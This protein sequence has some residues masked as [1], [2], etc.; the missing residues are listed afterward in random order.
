MESPPRM[1]TKKHEVD[2]K[3]RVF[4]KSWTAKYFFKEVSSK[5]LCLICSE[6]GAVFKDYKLSHHLE[7]KHTEKY[8]NLSEEERVRTTEALLAK[9]QKQQGL[10]TKLHATKKGQVKTRNALAHKNCQKKQAVP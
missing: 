1:S 7:T 3:C 9:L 4:N 6:H 8:R 5:A 10:F 2:A